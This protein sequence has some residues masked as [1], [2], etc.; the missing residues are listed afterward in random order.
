MDCLCVPQHWWKIGGD[1]KKTNQTLVQYNFS[2]SFDSGWSVGSNPNF[3]L[4][5]EAPRGQRVTFPLGLQVGK[6]LHAGPMP[7]KV[8]LQALYYAVRPTYT[9]GA[10]LPS[11][12][13]AFQ[14]QLT[15]VIPSLIHGH[16]PQS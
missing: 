5:W 3:T 6:L 14:L 7:L 12:K 1:G 10:A 15:P 4:N 9:Y 13:W 11:P 16:K 2:W 8:D